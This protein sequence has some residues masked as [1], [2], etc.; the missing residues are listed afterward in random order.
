MTELSE[1]EMEAALERYVRNQL[2]ITALNEEQEAIKGY[3]KGATSLPAGTQK[4]LGKFYIKVTSHTRIDQK[5]AEKELD[6][7]TLRRV[8]KL[9]VD[10]AKARAVLS[11][12]E[13]EAITKR[14]DNRIEI[15]LN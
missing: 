2:A 3:F 12:K 8:S 1:A 5:L 7:S 4:T 13:L 10:P 14:Y 15:G 6:H 9:T 11:E